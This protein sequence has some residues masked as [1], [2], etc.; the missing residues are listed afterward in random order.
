[1]YDRQIYLIFYFVLTSF[2]HN[3]NYLKNHSVWLSCGWLSIVSKKEKRITPLDH[4]FLIK[5][6]KWEPF[7][8]KLANL[9]VGMTSLKN[10]S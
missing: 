3:P 10:S 6:K 4:F 1:M 2:L 5:N 7:F 8:K 9:V